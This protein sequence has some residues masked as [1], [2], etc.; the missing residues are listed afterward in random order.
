MSQKAKSVLMR[1]AKAFLSG[2]AS[3]A[4]LITV[5]NVSTWTD[6]PSALN[7]AIISI[8]VGGI[9]GVFMGAEKWMNWEDSVA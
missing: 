7:A 2:A 9:N 1:F 4:A 5:S 8:I 6:L 3:A